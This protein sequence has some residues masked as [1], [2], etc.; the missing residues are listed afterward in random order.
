LEKDAE[1]RVNGGSH[2]RLKWEVVGAS[3]DDDSFVIEFGFS[4]C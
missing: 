3:L 2:S 4:W 1:R